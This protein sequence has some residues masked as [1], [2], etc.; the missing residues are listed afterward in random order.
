VL[1]TRRSL[2]QG[3]SALAIGGA[4]AKA[5]ASPG[6]FPLWEIRSKS[7]RVF[8]LAHTPPQALAW[9]N[10]HV[11]RLL[12]KCGQ[13]WN[14]TGHRSE[15]KVQDLMQ[16]YG[17]DHH[18]PLARRL[19]AGLR[20]RLA[21]AAKAVGVPEDSLSTFRPWLAGQTLEEAL[22]S[23]AGFD[24]PNAD[25]VLTAEALAQS[26]AV[27]SEFPTIDAVARWFATLPAEAEVQYLEYIIDEILMGHEKGQQIYVQWAEGMDT[28]AVA[29]VARMRQQYPRLYDAIV[30]ERNEGWVP[31]VRAMLDAEKP[32]MIVVGLYHMVGPDRIQRQLARAGLAIYRI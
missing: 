14:E 7:Q 22:F 24:K 30:R 10:E 4:L 18:P 27:R 20:A 9:K 32:S 8:L 29:W 16:Q 5:D 13:Y 26:I 12:K 17:I 19:D 21:D 31:R 11:E 2:L 15:A 6:S 1:A 25:N 28:A 3:L 23:A